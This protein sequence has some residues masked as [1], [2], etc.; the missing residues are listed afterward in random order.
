[1]IVFLRRVNGQVF[2][3]L[4]NSTKPEGEFK[5]ASVLL[6]KLTRNVTYM[7]GGGRGSKLSYHRQHERAKGGM[8]RETILIRNCKIH[9]KVLEV[10]LTFQ[11]TK[12]TVINTHVREMGKYVRQWIQGIKNSK[13]SVEEDSE[14]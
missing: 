7:G 12:A 1:M 5:P 4:K 6:R 8:K 10:G 14:S 9:E 11:N 3:V 13:Q 2:T